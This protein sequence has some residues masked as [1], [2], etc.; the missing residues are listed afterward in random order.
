MSA[1]D[2]CGKADERARVNMCSE[3]GGKR[4]LPGQQEKS[5]YS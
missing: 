5:N 4:N 2:F 3:E 1:N